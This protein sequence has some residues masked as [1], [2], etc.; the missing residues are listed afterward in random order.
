LE[1]F[2]RLFCSLNTLKTTALSVH[3]TNA[4]QGFM[5]KQKHCCVAEWAKDHRKILLIH[6]L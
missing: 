5:G 2:E 6:F 3:F 1:E 4:A